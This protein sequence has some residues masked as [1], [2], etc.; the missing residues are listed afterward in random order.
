MKKWAGALRG[1]GLLCAALWGALWLGRAG[2]PARPA[3]AP[4]GLL[5]WVELDRKRLIVYENGV[6]TAVFPI[7]AGARD[8]PSPVGVYRVSYRFATELSGFGT[9]FMGLNVPFGQ[10]GLHGTNAPGSI[11]QNA[12]HGCIRLRVGDA[13]RLYRMAP[14]GT[15]VVLEGGA[16]GALNAGLRTLRE[17][18][19]GSDVQ[20]L[21]RRLI[22]RGF[23]QG[24]ADGVLGAATRQAVIRARRALGLSTGDAADWALQTALGMALFE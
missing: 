15:R 17:G 5:I 18:D 23:L 11:G 8:T 10:Y 12:S 1:A 14:N 4:Q 19:R 13:E 20:L 21:Q 6:E 24:S 7:A 3:A 16:Y 9:R 22:Q 2:P